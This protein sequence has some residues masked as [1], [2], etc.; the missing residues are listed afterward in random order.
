VKQTEIEAQNIQ[1]QG[2]NAAAVARFR[3]RITRGQIP[4]DILGG[5]A[6][7]GKSILSSYATT[8]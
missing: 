8:R 6:G 1:G 2:T 3:S 7:G 4:F 5:I